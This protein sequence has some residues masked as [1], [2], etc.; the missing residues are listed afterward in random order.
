LQDVAGDEADG[1][2][3]RAVS[4]RR[5]FDVSVA[6]MVAGWLGEVRLS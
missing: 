3:S 1:F 4:V 2:S 5:P 6:S